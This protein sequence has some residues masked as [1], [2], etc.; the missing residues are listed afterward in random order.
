MELTKQV[1]ESIE[2]CMLK[3]NYWVEMQQQYLTKFNAT[4]LEIDY[5]NAHICQLLIE[6]ESFRRFVD[7]NKKFAE[8]YFKCL[9]SIEKSYNKIPQ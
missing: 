6:L 4:K 7:S 1:K 5:I 9:N 3:C 2:I 8:K